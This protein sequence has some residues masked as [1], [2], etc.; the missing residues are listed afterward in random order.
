LN[1]QSPLG[2][3]TPDLRPAPP[4]RLKQAK[5]IAIVSSGNFL[6]MYDFMV[7]G[8]YAP[9][10]AKAF[11]PVGNEFASLMLTLMTFGAGFLM[12][13][14]GAL[15]LGAYI[16]KHG[17]RKGLMLTLGLMAI[18]TLTIA[19]MPGYAT[20]GLA[21]PILIVL[22]RLVQ[23]LSAGVEVGGVSVYLGEIAPPSQ[24]GFFVAWQS[25]SQ[26][27]AV[28][29]AALIGIIANAYLT[30]AEMTGWGWRI[31]FFVGCLMVPFLLLIRRLL[32][33]TPAFLAR[34]EQPNLRQIFS[35]VASNWS[36]VLRGM[37]VAVMTTVF[38][39]MITAYTP[40]Y[41]SKV[42]HLTAKDSLVVT[43]CVGMANFILLPLMGALSDRVGRRPLL[44]GAAL[45]ALVSGYPLMSWLVSAPSLERLMTV[46]LFF[47][48]VYATYNGAMVVFLTEIM[49]ARVRTAG[50]SLAYSL[51]TAV[52][53]GFT[54]AIST[55]LIQL[56]HDRAIPGAWLSAAALIGL[57]A[58]LT[59]GGRKVPAA[60][61]VR[62]VA[63]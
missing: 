32:E 37:M 21:A 29:F 19:A 4:S 36:L 52:F 27:V 20:I 40:T 1:I 31:P 49:P 9:A 22:G 26:Q 54:P 56:T 42:L 51:A 58:T 10:I 16:D 24:K 48:L 13:P 61:G 7:F 59:L 57:G 46:Q 33:E 60:A 63:P 53:G 17:R 25:A 55:Y 12:R 50:F 38:F 41:G 2:E 11:F 5:S 34:K 8:Y 18:G 62:E 28:V 47:A 39:Y 44:I 6:E 30:P 43:L 23:G 14:V 15:L 3:A 35:T 45:V